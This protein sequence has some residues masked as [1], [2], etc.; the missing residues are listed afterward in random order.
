MILI[1]RQ[2][3]DGLPGGCKQGMSNWQIN[4]SSGEKSY[5]WAIERLVKEA[6]TGGLQKFAEMR[7]KKQLSEL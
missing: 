3:C 5:M 4:L 6:G 2:I 7:R 1:G